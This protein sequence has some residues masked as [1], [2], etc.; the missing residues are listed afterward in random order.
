M[1]KTTEEKFDDLAQLILE[2]LRATRDE[3]SAVLMPADLREKLFP[4]GMEELIK[5]TTDRAEKMWDAFYE[6]KG[7]MT[8]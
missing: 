1:G 7:E 6:L 8:V 3:E 4:E 2:L 5:R